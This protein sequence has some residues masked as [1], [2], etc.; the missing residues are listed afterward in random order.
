MPRT[1]KKGPSVRSLTRQ[2]SELCTANRDLR[3]RL[4]GAV[5]VQSEASL[6]TEV[7]ADTAITGTVRTAEK[8]GYKVY[9]TFDYKGGLNYVAT[10]HERA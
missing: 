7:P 1:K 5:K 4:Y 8:L 9:V 2:I 6:R 3:N 10:K